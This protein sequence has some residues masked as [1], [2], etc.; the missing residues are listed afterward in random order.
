MQETGCSWVGGVPGL[1][2]PP[3]VVGAF[4]DGEERVL[5]GNEIGPVGAEG[6][7]GSP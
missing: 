3:L 1:G 5:P 6:A 7:G 2:K 4:L